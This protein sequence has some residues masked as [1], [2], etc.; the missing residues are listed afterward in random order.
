MCLKVRYR[1]LRYND[2]AIACSPNISRTFR[3]V[4]AIHVHISSVRQFC[5]NSYLTY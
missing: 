2:V 5:K 1:F 4:I 3:M